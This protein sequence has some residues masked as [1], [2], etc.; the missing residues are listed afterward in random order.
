MRRSA[1]STVMRSSR[2]ASA[3]VRG[4]PAAIHRRTASNAGSVIGSRRPPPCGTCPLG[5]FKSRLLSGAAGKTRRP[6]ASDVMA[7]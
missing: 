5:F 2:G 1:G 7:W 6:F 3:G 4:Q